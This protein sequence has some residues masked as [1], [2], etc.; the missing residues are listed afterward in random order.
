MT[1][2]NEQEMILRFGMFERQI[3]E[4]QQQLEAVERGI[5][6]LTTLNF[7]LDDLVGGTDKEIY[8]PIGKGIFA[9]A[10]LLSEELNVD[11]GN[12]NFV[13]KSIPEAKELI[14]DQINKLGHIKTELEKNMEQMGE[15]LNNMMAGLQ[16]HECNH[17]H[18]HC[19]EGEECNCG[20]ECTCEKD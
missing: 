7:G 8:A 9:K 12:G 11:V 1:D 17:E 19:H 4:L 13:K 2:N 5:M 20:D 15:E 14:S 16:P 18:C 10:K 3:R 6:E